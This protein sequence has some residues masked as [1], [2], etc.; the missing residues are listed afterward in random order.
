MSTWSL[1]FCPKQNRVRCH[2][3]VVLSI[4]SKE[5]TINGNC[6]SAQDFLQVPSI[7]PPALGLPHCLHTA[8][9]SCRD[10]PCNLQRVLFCSQIPSQ[11]G[12]KDKYYADFPY[13]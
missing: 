11:S 2:R 4:S 9:T 3:S 7:F 1:R 12:C 10:L 6:Q 8:S 13:Y 5:D